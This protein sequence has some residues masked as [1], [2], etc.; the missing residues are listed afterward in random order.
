MLN[1]LE[2]ILFP[3]RC[4]SCGVFGSYL[5][6][7]CISIIRKIE[8]NI[9]PVCERFSIDGQTH[10]R[11]QTRYTIDGLVSFWQYE[12]M[13]RKIVHKLKYEPFLFAAFSEITKKGIVTLKNPAFQN[14][15]SSNPVL[16]P[17][18]LHWLRFNWRGYNQGALVAGELGK[19]WNL[20][21]EEKLLIRKKRTKPQVEL[22]FEDRKENIK[23][24]FSLNPCCVL[25]LPSAVILIDDVWTT[26]STLKTCAS[27][28][29]RNGAKSVWGLTLAR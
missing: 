16:V 9:C 11:C 23:D 7:Q 20:K 21:V 3:K 1:F 6:H 13:V 10:P 25:P 19:L 4:L 8:Q 2:D 14:Y 5:C 24:A 12:G 29:K 28:L 26:G 17:I 15:L 18:P 27:L 22:K